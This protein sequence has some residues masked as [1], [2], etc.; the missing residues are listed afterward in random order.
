MEGGRFPR[1]AARPAGAREG[2]HLVPQTTA[3]QA[4]SAPS[5]SARRRS[6]WP[7]VLAALCLS[8]PLHLSLA[9]WLS[10]ILV[11]RPQRVEQAVLIEAPG[12]SHGGEADPAE[13]APRQA[14]EPRSAPPV[15][16]AAPTRDAE[17]R[18]QQP[19]AAGGAVL[20]VARSAAP[21]P[22]AMDDG[23]ATGPGSA[24]VGGGG[25]GSGF[26]GTS[27]FGAHGTG[28]RFAFI[29]D[30]SGSMNADGK[31][32]RAL[33]E[34]LRSVD[35]LPDFA[36]FRVLLFDTQVASFPERGF[37]RARDSEVDRLGHWL[38]GALPVGGTTPMVAFDRVMGE[39][40]P[41]DAIFF[42]TDGEIGKGDP[43]SIIQRVS[44]RDGAVPVHCV[45][46]GDARAAEQL[47]AIARA[48]GGEYRFVPLEG[49]K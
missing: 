11:E 3:T 27:F 14:P 46:F 9:L 28:K 18:W 25:G 47:Q 13:A 16:T 34:L 45:A 4:A 17:A 2:T 19:E 6:A 31:M 40:S 10:G 49:R 24:A 12:G 23:L 30:K 29:V 32:E 26:A 5:I 33:R 35:A 7:V 41:P 38:G 1:I 39:G 8:L 15:A 43:A 44:G 37:A 48:T 21:V 42:M 22:G 20:D 36:Q